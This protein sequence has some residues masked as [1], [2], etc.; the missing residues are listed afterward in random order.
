MDMLLGDLL[1]LL[2]GMAWAATTVV[3]RCSTLARASAS[4]TLL[5]QLV[6]AFVLLLAA[7]FAL[8]QTAIRPT[9]MAWGAVL[10]QS[11]VVSFASFLVWFWLL[12]NYLASS[13]GVFSFITPLFG[14]GFGVWLLDEKLEPSFLLGAFF[15]LAG[16]VLVSS[17]A[18]LQ[19][20]A[21]GDNG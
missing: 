8:G 19:R 21:A 5:Y 9:P 18:W 15:V 3:I 2:G 10:F 12:R 6:G 20:L 11:L 13:L 17:Q 1:A 7:A 4:L 14:V 16:V